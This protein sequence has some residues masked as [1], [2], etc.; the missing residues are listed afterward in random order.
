[1]RILAVVIVLEWEPLKP[2]EQ[3]FPFNDDHSGVSHT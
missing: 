1:M 3:G 2:K